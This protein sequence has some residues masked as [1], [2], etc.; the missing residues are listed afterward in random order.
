MLIVIVVEPVA[1]P[2]CVTAEI[3]AAA[4]DVTTAAV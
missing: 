2:T 4:L 1:L 3:V